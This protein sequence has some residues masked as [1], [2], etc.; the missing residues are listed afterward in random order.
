MTTYPSLDVSS[1]CSR[2]LGKLDLNQ[3]STVRH[4]DLGLK[5]G[6]EVGSG[7]VPDVLKAMSGVIHD[8]C[9]VLYFPKRKVDL[10]RKGV[11]VRIRRM[12]WSFEALSMV[13]EESTGPG[14]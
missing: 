9:R 11:K 12:T 5:Q 3:P 1:P 14:Q 2:C 7:K 10:G 6:V 8:Y 13:K 4:A